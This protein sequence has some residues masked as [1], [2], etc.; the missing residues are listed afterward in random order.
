[1]SCTAELSPMKAIAHHKLA[2]FFE[3]K[4]CMACWVTLESAGLTRRLFD[5]PSKSYL[6]PEGAPVSV[7]DIVPRMSN[8][9]HQLI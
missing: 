8:S 2:R 4:T 5:K 1:M 7:R 9:K 3:I 6:W